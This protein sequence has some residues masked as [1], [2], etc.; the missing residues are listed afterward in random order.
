MIRYFILHPF[1]APVIY[2]CLGLDI[3]IWDFNIKISN[4]YILSETAQ[5]KFKTE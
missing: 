2:N 1:P 5:L 4:R 3:S